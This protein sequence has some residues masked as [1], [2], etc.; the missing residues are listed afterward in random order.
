[1]DIKRIES[2]DFNMMFDLIRREFMDCVRKDYTEEGTLY[3]IE[4]FCTPDSAYGKKIESGQ[5][6]AFGAYDD[7]R[8]AGVITVSEHGNISC[9]FVETEYHRQGIG[10]M[11]F[12][13]AK[14]FIEKEQMPPYVIKL[15]ASPYAIPFYEALGFRKTDDQAEYHGMVYT[16]MALEVLC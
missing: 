5:E 6:T 13:H 16:P 2:M 14:D 1:M 11:L 4:N 9:A 3:F 8:L 15:N 12:L 10:R 7:D